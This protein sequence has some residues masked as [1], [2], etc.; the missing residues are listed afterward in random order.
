MD[1]A[2]SMHGKGEYTVLMGKLYGKKPLQRPRTMWENIKMYLR[3]TG[4]GGIFSLGGGWSPTGS[5]RHD[6]H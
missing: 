4:Q 1:R 6:G 5:T 3:E 2:Y